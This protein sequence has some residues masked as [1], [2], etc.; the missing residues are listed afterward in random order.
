M[1]AIATGNAKLDESIMEVLPD[2][3]EGYIVNYREFLLRNDDNYQ[4]ET[5]I[6]SNRLKGTTIEMEELL[7]D[8]KQSNTRVIFLTNKEKISE[9]KMCLKLNIYDLVFDPIHIE[10]IPYIVKNPK[11]FSDI[12]SL[13]VKVM[14]GEDIE[15]EEDEKDKKKVRLKDRLK[16]KKEVTGTTVNSDKETGSGIKVIEKIVEVDKSKSYGP[17]TIAIGGTKAGA[18]ST[19]LTLTIARYLALLKKRVAIVEL[20]NKPCLANIDKE[21]RIDIYAQEFVGYKMD[22]PV[23][24]LNELNRNDYNYI[25]IDLGAI[26]D[27]KTENECNSMSSS[28]VEKSEY[29]YEMN[30]ANLPIIVHPGGVWNTKY[31]IPMTLY[32]TETKAFK[33]AITHSG[34]KDTKQVGDVINKYYIAPY[35]LDIYDEQTVEFLENL[36]GDMLPYKKERKNI[37]KKILKK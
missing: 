13:Y 27:Y 8:L 6:I 7:F 34:K 11:E 18:G 23:N 24:Y 20:N 15:E 9:I 36:L 22:N 3:Y 5:V 28:T 30:R 33:L 35:H 26:F 25:V 10:K 4:F 29:F 21:T 1:I 16:K 37:F 31:L 32:E 17:I 12:S 19:V 14:N 2:G